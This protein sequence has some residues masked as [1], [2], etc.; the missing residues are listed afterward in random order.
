MGGG[1]YL[2]LHVLKARFRHIV[3]I[4]YFTKSRP[5]SGA[6]FSRAPMGVNY[7]FTPSPSLD[8]SYA[9]RWR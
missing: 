5:G 7:H 3:L 8:R 1:T 9:S 2:L 6:R 4:L